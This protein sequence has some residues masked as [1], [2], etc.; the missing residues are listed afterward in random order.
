MRKVAVFAV[1]LAFALAF[2]MLL[3][4]GDINKLKK[5]LSHELQAEDYT[6][7]A[8]T[9]AELG[10][11]GSVE[12]VKVIL[13]V[14]LNERIKSHEVFS[15]SKEALSG[16]TDK[17]AIEYI[18][19]VAKKKS[20][21]WRVKMLLAEVLG[22]LNGEGVL[23]ALT[24][25][26]KDRQPEVVREAVI[27]LKK[28]GDIEAVDELIE[29]LA[30]L[31]KEKGRPW[32][33]A[34]RALHEL[35]GGYDFTTAAKWRQFWTQKKEEVKKEAD[36]PDTA[37]PVAPGEVKTGLLEEEKKKAPKFFGR[38]ILSKKIVFVIDVSGSMIMKDR[39][40]GGGEA[41]KGA[42]QGASEYSK[43]S[44]D[45][46]RIERAKNEL[47]KAIAALS[48]KAKFNVIAF[49]NGVSPWQR[50]KLVLATS[51]NKQAA[52]AFADKFSANGGTYTDDA[53][54][55]AFANKE[56][57]TIYFLSDGA[58]ER[59][60]S[61]IGQENP[62]NIKLIDTILTW[63][64]SENK[65]RKVK[66]F[67]FGFDGEGVWDPNRGPK[68]PYHQKAQRFID[69]MKKLASESGGEYKSIK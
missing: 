32:I 66:I 57:D 40:T 67:T 35:T 46:M 21:D 37:K 44:K 38:E 62:D 3:Y 2:A 26:L 64:R 7:A 4:A 8:S 30:R 59:Y 18:C 16:I 11:D 39:G 47:K 27:S 42:R 6:S 56:A 22:D 45:R 36:S 23:D 24:T 20:R 13:T 54:K 9:I 63:F 28:L 48:P 58:P 61:V 65:F 10:E 68:P 5:K 52:I 55:E 1:V 29:A 14:A 15:A 25:L 12:A 53:L 43:M 51:R 69:F 49:S 31:E 41:G 50:R 33:E 34:R 60:P 19:S 17:A